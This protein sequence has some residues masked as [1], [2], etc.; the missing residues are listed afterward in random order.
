MP[1]ERV[2]EVHIAGGLIKKSDSGPVYVDAHEREIIPET[3][4]M[5][6]AMLPQLP[7]V[8]AVCFECENV[9]ETLVKE[10][11]KKIRQRVQEKSACEALV[12]SLEQAA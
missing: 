7:N 5:F 6:D 9:N 1:V 10:T 3:W 2:V 11:L 12:A 4:Q 8:K